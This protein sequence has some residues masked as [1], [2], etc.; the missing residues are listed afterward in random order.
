MIVE[1][2]LRPTLFVLVIVAGAVDRIIVL[3]EGVVAD[4]REGRDVDAYFVQKRM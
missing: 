1:L 4:G 3:D 2:I